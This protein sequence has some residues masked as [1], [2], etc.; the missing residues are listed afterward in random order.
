MQK[1]VAALD[2]KDPNHAHQQLEALWVTWGMNAVDTDL[3]RKLI[4]HDDFRVR[5][6]AV[7]V[8]RYNFDRFTDSLDLLKKAAADDHGRVRLESV[9]AA[10]W[11]DKRE[12]L[13]VVTIAQ[14]KGLDGWSKAA[15]EAAAA[16]LQGK[17]Q[18]EEV[19]NPMPTIPEHLTDAEKESF[20][21]GH[22][23]YFRDGHCATCHQKDGKG[24]DP[25]FPP[26]NDSIYVHG[27]S[28]RL[29]KLTLHG[30]M[31]PFE[32]HGKKYDGQVPMTPFGMLSDKEVADVLTFTRNSFDN[33]ASAITP[34]EVAKVREATKDQTGFYQMEELLKEHPLE[35]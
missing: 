10:T 28:E 5:S 19:E 12:A 21:A 16:R 11:Y 29:I 32:L 14:G 24:L 33:K 3:L 13:E 7:R 30:V 15:T 35:K 4:A 6:A 17:A 34:D 9:I 27:S 8:L 18:K 1:W 22:E 26:L 31:G 20:K 25:A 23:V 2:A